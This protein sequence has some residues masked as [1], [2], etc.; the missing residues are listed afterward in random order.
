MFMRQIR[1]RGTRVPSLA[2]ASPW[3]VM[4]WAEDGEER[5]RCLAR[6]FLVPALM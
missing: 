4:L 5:G 3:W 6:G 2:S 1:G